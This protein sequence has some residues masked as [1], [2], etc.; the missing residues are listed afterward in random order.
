MSCI[1][2]PNNP[3]DTILAVAACYRARYLVPDS[4]RPHTT[5]A[6]YTGKATYGR[7]ILR[8]TINDGEQACQVH[9]IVR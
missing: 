6:L 1:A 2:I 8:R 3:P 4:T 9:A 7:L 5:D